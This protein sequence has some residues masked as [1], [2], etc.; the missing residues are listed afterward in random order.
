M[1]ITR[2]DSLALGAAALGA[3]S[4]PLIGA[5]AAVD[6][7]PTADVK[8]LNY[9]IEKGAALHILRPA[10]FVDADEVVFKANTQKFIETTG[11]DVKVDWVSWEDLAPQ[12]A[13]VA[14]T[15][16]GA[17]VIIGFASSPHIYTTKI[18]DMS[19]LGNYLGAKY[20]G[21][22]DLAVT[23]G[24]KWKT[25]EW[26][27]IPMGGGTGPTVYR[28]SWVK[29]AGFDKIPDDL[30]GFLDLCP[31]APE[32]RSPLRLFSRPRPGRRHGVRGVGAMVAPMPSWWMRCG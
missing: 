23:Y 1:T 18:A 9:Q 6:D 10:K 22:Y 25:K 16:A 20:G 31:E 7:V 17:D 11:V 13:V 27:S 29:E 21:W 32:N 12:T 19:D 28:V 3:T 24:T 15:G 2:R 14:N 30:P 5:R 26:I 4:V 8:P